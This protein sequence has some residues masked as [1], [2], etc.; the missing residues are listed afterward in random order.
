MGYVR[1]RP[2]LPGWLTGII[3]TLAGA[4]IPLLLSIGS[5]TTP[6]N[7]ASAV[8]EQPTPTP[9]T[10]VIG[11]GPDHGAVW[12]DNVQASVLSVIRYTPAASA[13]GVGKG[14]TGVKV[15]IKITNGSPAPLD[16]TLSSV[17]LK[18]GKDGVQAPQVFDIE[19]N[20]ALGFEGT[21]LSGRSATADY[22]FSVPPDNLDLL[23]VQ[24]AP[25][26]NY[27]VAVFE[28]P[29]AA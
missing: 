19:N 23:N 24:V 10:E 8:G 7:A 21:L 6:A 1:V 14:E 5:G 9:T 13:A 15:T 17:R 29:A 22:G 18:S 3:I 11:F 28:G 12:D 4:A 20:L 27:A 2:S 25:T 16:L 26:P